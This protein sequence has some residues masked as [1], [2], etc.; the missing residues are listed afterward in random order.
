MGNLSCVAPKYAV[1]VKSAANCQACRGWG[2]LI[3]ES[4]KG[5]IP[6]AGCQ[7][8]ADDESARP[9]VG[10]ARIRCHSVGNVVR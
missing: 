3:A 1:D 7:G 4:G 6:C 2:T 9:A 8:A 5:L 10:C